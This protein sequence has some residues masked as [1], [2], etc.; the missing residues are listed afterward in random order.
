MS[1]ARLSA[2]ATGDG[3]RVNPETGRYFEDRTGI[4]AD[5]PSGDYRTGNPTW[6]AGTGRVILHAARNEFVSFQVIVECDKAVSGVSVRLASLSGPEGAVISER[7]IA[8][9]KAWYA[10]VYQ[11]STGYETLSLGPGWYPDALLPSED[12]GGISF[13]IP[14]ARNAI[15]AGQRNQTVWVDIYVP[16]D[17]AEA[18]PGDYTGRLAVC[19]PA[20]ERDITVRLKVWDFALPDEIHCRGDI[21]NR[22]LRE[23][24]PSQELAYYHMAHRHRFHPG[25]PTYKPD[26]RV[27]G[28]TVNIDWSE[29]D[30]RLTKYF[31]GSAFTDAHDYWGPGYGVPIPHVIL[32]FDINK[33]NETG[34]AWPIS[35]PP[36]GRT[37]E[38]QTVW[39]EAARQFKEHFEADPT[40][41]KVKRIVF[42]DGLDESYNEEAYEK[43]RY[44]CDLLSRGMGKG[45]FQYRIDGGYSWEAMESL[46]E[47]VGLWVCHSIGFDH[48]KMA[49]FRDKGVEPWFYGPMIYEARVNSS[50]GSNTFTDLDLLTCRGMGWAAWKHKCGYCQWE[51]DSFWDQPNDCYDPEKN[52][53]EAVN[54]RKGDRAFNGSG[55]LIYRGS[56]IGTDEP[57]GSIRLKAH[58][59]GF[60]DY[61]YFWLLAQAGQQE[62][63][64]RLVDS[65]VHAIPFGRRSV[66]NIEIWK[67]DPAAWD[68]VRIQA[69]ELL[70]A[71]SQA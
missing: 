37:P 6:E 70:D 66:G 7:N 60:Q 71:G 44:Y 54:F 63:A 27:E 48:E 58:R 18:P 5:Y 21:Y 22:S 51:F 11:G 15:G 42:L 4:H 65:V 8:L 34:R 36:E 25:V 26:V 68:D 16:C 29:Y 46:Q 14:D 24:P 53:T 13:D 2:W 43:M 47:H 28:S 32:P 9:F 41:R 12:E 40:W 35:L 59:R 17:R 10:R 61:E 67:N 50:A 30:E 23:M 39:T 38:Y 31:D 55:L 19:S 3:V 33:R 49:H 64:D 56:F 52:W 57:V 62:Q 69:G 20:G 45:W 1:Q